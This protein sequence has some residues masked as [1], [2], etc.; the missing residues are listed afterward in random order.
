MLSF[1]SH[2]SDIEAHF[3]SKVTNVEQKMSFSLE[4]LFKC[5]KAC[6]QIEVENQKILDNIKTYTGKD[7]DESILKIANSEFRNNSKV[8][9]MKE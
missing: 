3:G 9:E 4:Q 8:I 5:E 6:Q 2:F 7:Q 1:A